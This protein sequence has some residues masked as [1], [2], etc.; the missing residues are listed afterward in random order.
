MFFLIFISK[1]TNTDGS[2]FFNFVYISDFDWKFNIFKIKLFGNIFITF[3]I[4]LGLWPV[5]FKYLTKDPLKPPL[6]SIFGIS[7]ILFI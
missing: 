7:M 3:L 2:L 6:L 4:L 5:G 1:N